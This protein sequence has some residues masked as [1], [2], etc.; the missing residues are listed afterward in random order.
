MKK[1]KDNMY[2]GKGAG[3]IIFFILLFVFA[4]WGPPINFS[5]VTQS[6]GEPLVVTGQGK[7]FVTPDIGKITV[8]IEENG[9]SL[10]TVEDNANKKT[11]T[12]TDALK[13]L[14]IEDKDIKTTSYYLYPQYDYS[15]SNRKITGYQVS[16][17]YQ[18]TIKDIDKVNDVIVAATNAGANITGDISFEVNDKTNKEKLQEARELAVAEAKEKAEGLAKSAGITLGKI[19]NINESQANDQRL[20]ALPMAGGGSEKSIAEPD[21]QPGTTEINVTVSLSYEI[22]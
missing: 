13:K 9:S 19:V 14:G 10:K 3:I 22:R 8:G 17:T 20:Y 1:M 15:V 12:I 11:K 16:A 2:R 7:V 21:I 5:T 6:K 4:K 18:V